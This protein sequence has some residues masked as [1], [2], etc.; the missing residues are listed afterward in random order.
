MRLLK[1]WMIFANCPQ[2]AERHSS[3]LLIQGTKV[4]VASVMLE[5]R[6]YIWNKNDGTLFQNPILMS[7]T[8]QKQHENHSSSSLSWWFRYIDFPDLLSDTDIMCV[9]C[10]QPLNIYHERL[11]ALHWDRPARRRGSGVQLTEI[12]NIAAESGIDVELFQIR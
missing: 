2:G 4:L 12:V 11:T 10:D 8:P 6:S 5:R 3:R 1:W 9:L 7:P